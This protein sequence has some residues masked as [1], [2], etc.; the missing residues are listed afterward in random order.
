MIPLDIFTFV[1]DI[2]N[3][4]EAATKTFGGAL[5]L[6]FI[7]YMAARA[8]FAIA[9]IIG[10]VIAA[11]LVIAALVGGTDFVAGLFGQ[12]LS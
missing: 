11:G 1:S 3:D 2:S 4:L 8:K 12:T 9:A 6:V 5:A 10:A 7:V